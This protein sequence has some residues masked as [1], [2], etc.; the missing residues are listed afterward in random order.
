LWDA[1]YPQRQGTL[2]GD[3][4]S[5]VELCWYQLAAVELSEQ[6]GFSDLEFAS[7]SPPP[8]Q[9]NSLGIASLWGDDIITLSNDKAG[10]TLREILAATNQIVNEKALVSTGRRV[11]GKFLE[12]RLLLDLD[13]DPKPDPVTH[14]QRGCVY[15]DTIKMRFF[16]PGSG[17]VASDPIFGKLAAIEGRLKWMRVEKHPHTHFYTRLT[18]LNFPEIRELHKAG[19]PVTLQREAGGISAPGSLSWP[20]K[21]GQM[22]DRIRSALWYSKWSDELRNLLI[23]INF[24]DQ[25]GVMLLGAELVAD[26]PKP[27]DNIVNYLE[28]AG[29]EIPRDG[30]GKIWWRGVARLC[31]ADQKLSN[32]VIESSL[33]LKEMTRARA[34]QQMLFGEVK[35]NLPK[36]SL[37]NWQR[38]WDA[39]APLTEGLEVPSV[40]EFLETFPSESALADHLRWFPRGQWYVRDDPKIKDILASASL[41]ITGLRRPGRGA[42]APPVVGRNPT[43]QIG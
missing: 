41:R 35:K 36:N 15:L 13:K 6:Y 7:A 19:Y 9:V 12:E 8:D 29:Y 34:F 38:S 39:M 32:Q 2:L 20:N 42:R 18:W 37:R 43:N 22:T 21:V 27:I 23:R 40:E 14:R 1:T 11:L 3:P 24:I 17:R 4:T 16:S 5:F 26:L 25:H 28:A 30:R 31:Q 10:R 33:L